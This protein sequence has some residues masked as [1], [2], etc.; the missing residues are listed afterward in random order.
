MWGSVEC[1]VIE[2]VDS[3]KS[4]LF[5]KI[6]FLKLMNIT[7]SFIEHKL[8]WL[9]INWNL[10][11]KEQA[12]MRLPFESKWMGLNETEWNQDYR[13]VLE[14]LIQWQFMN[15]KQDYVIPAMSDI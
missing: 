10:F 7:T 6:L 9:K 12:Y 2:Q 1:F 4:S 8:I 5:L 15:E 3:N 11:T 13:I 14:N